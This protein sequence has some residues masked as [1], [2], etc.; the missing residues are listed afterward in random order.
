MKERKKNKEQCPSSKLQ[1]YTLL[2]SKHCIICFLDQLG[3]PFYAAEHEHSLEQ[4]TEIN[5]P[6]TKGCDKPPTY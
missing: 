1:D 3:Y 4:E 6:G 2:P 5:F